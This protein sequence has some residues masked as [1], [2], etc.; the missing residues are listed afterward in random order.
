MNILFITDKNVNPIL[1]G[2]ERITYVL[3]DGFQRLCGHRCF[4]AFTQRVDDTPSFF[5]EELLLTKGNERPELNRF[6]KKNGIDII[7]AQGSAENVN[8]I[9]DRIRN[10]INDVP[11]CKLL[12][13]FHNMPGF[14][15]IRIDAR[16]LLYRIFHLQNFKTN[17]KYLCMQM[18]TPLLKPMLKSHLRNKYLPAYLAADKV[19]LL[20]EAFIPEYAKLS[21]VQPD[22]HFA[23]I[24]NATSFNQELD[25]SQYDAV[26]K[27]EVLCVARFDDRHKRISSALR[28]WSLIEKI[29]KFSDWRLR[30]VG[31]GE[32]EDYYFWLTNKLKLKNVSFEGKRDPFDYYRAATVFMMTSAFEGFGIVLVEAQQMGAVPMAF[33]SFATVHDIITDGVNGFLVQ[34]GDIQAYAS[35]LQTLMDDVGMRKQM[36]EAGIRMLDRFSVENITRKWNGLF[37]SLK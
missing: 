37:E 23:A 28:I 13:V 20:T 1:G 9:I 24:G 27:K 14:E 26:K 18:F 15:Y 25:M 22:D 21:G 32:D 10:A 5:A 12:F 17:L 29:Q 33:D 8:S 31:Y 11:T 2:I 3:A 34:D 7:I 16:V 6:V 4:S 36:A 35:K 19:V 30:I